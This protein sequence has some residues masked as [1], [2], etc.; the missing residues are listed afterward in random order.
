MGKLTVFEIMVDNP[1]GMVKAGDTVR[2]QLLL[3]LCADLEVNG[4]CSSV[5]ADGPAWGQSI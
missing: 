2:G 3:E 5:S 4:E 1:G